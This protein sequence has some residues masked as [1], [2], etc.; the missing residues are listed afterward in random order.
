MLI[1]AYSLKKTSPLFAII[2]VP[3]IAFQ[4]LFPNK[5]MLFLALFRIQIHIFSGAGSEASQY[6]QYGTGMV[7]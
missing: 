2:T 4:T 1:L 5:G 6:G 3:V 7:G